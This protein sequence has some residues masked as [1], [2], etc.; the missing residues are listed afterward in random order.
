MTTTGDHSERADGARLADE[1]RLLVDLVVERARPWLDGVAAAGHG[2]TRPDSAAPR[3]EAGEDAGCGGRDRCPLCLVVALCRGERVDVAARV[4]E[5]VTQVLA[6]LRAVLADR[7][8]PEDG[9]HMP[10]FRPPQRNT[11]PA[12]RRARRVQHVAVRPSDR[13]EPDAHDRS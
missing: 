13:W 11:E 5:Q 8:E 1:I 6:L 9:L 3:Q 2:G 4:L 10:G 12:Q 7:W